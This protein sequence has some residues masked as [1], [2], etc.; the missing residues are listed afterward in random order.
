[1][2][3]E[4][5]PAAFSSS[6]EN[7]SSH[8]SPSTGLDGH[9]ESRT[10]SCASTSQCLHVTLPSTARMGRIPDCPN[11]AKPLHWDTL[12]ASPPGLWGRKVIEAK[13]ML[14]MEPQPPS[15]FLMAL[16]TAPTH[17][18]FLLITEET[19]H[20]RGIFGLNSLCQAGFGLQMHRSIVLLH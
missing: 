11:G 17:T 20:V 14:P 6:L 5:L 15:P 9:R 4:Q 8:E 16:P 12:K 1:M 13:G 3:G 10:S 2:L 19:F 18:F 7:T